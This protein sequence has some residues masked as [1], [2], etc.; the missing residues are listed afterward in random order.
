MLYRH[1]ELQGI[2]LRL[3]YNEDKK[4][5]VEEAEGLEKEVNNVIEKAELVIIL[6]KKRQKEK[7]T[8][9]TLLQT[10]SPKSPAQATY[11]PAHSQSS[12]SD[13]SGNCNQRF[14]PLEIPV[15]N[16]EKSKFEDFWG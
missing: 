13:D 5:I 1:E 11:L 7:A 12:N 16:G 14:K 6:E 9:K 10:P 4:A 3:G 15:S 2:Y 8:K